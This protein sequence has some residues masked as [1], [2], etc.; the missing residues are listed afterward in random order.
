[1]NRLLEV[2]YYDYEE[3]PIAENQLSTTEI[4]N[5]TL[6]FLDT[7]F[8]HMSENEYDEAC[9]KLI[10]LCGAIKENAFEVGFYAGVQLMTNRKDF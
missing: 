5:A 2:I 7:Y 6:S 8:S 1:M 9:N 3:K 4:R 10:D